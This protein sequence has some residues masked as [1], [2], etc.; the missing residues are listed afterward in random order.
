M[1]LETRHFDAFAR[2]ESLIQPGFL[3]Y[4][5]LKELFPDARPES[6]NR[7]RSLF[8]SFYRLN[9]GGLTDVFKDRYFDILFSKNVVVNGQVA[10]AAIM[11]EL[12]QIR[13]RKGDCAMHYSFVSKL[14]NIHRESSP[15]F[16]QHVTHFFSEYAPPAHIDNFKRIEWFV[17][18]LDRVSTDYQAWAADDRMQVILNKLKS[19]DP[20]LERCHVVR[21]VDF[22]VWN[23]GALKLL[24]S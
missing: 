2:A 23:V 10:C 13:R 7:F 1:Q 20:R 22:L 5:E 12:Y 17:G 6:R 4:L 3:T 19:R 9:R 18:F 21:L 15:I 24:A 8:T 16:D 14:V 11:L